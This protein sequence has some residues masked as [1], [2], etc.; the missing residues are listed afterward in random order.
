MQ[1]LNYYKLYVN[2]HLWTKSVWSHALHKEMPFNTVDLELSS[3]T[4]KAD[5]NWGHT[6]DC[7]TKLYFTL[8]ALLSSHSGRPRSRAKGRLF[9]LPCRL[10]F[11]LSF[12]HFLPKIRGG[13][14]PSLSLP[15]DPPLY[16]HCH[17]NKLWRGLAGIA[18]TCAVMHRQKLFWYS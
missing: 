7:W 6:F 13:G 12:L 5:L 15:L 3:L 1:L 16:S 10:F 11:L 17:A 18:I 2:L 14:Q 8:A 4:F 9:C